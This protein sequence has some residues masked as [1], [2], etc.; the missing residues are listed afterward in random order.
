LLD[1]HRDGA[2][3]HAGALGRP[4][5]EILRRFADRLAAG[6][7]GSRLRGDTLWGALLSHRGEIGSLAHAALGDGARPVRA[8]MFDK[9]PSANWA[10]SWHQDRTIPV[11]ERA[12]A[13]GFGP[14]SRKDGVWHVA[15]PI[16]VL[17]RMVTLRAHL[18]DCDEDNAPLL[19]ALGS[20]RCGKVAATEA[21]AR[22][23]ERPM[24][25]CLAAMGDVW[26][27]RTPILHASERAAR[28]R[29]RRVLQVDF[30]AF[31]LPEPLRWKGLEA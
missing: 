4:T 28:P 20:H 19:I 18:D 9:S 13:P 3:L 24:H 22:A 23:G 17:D 25:T 29:R 12:E 31:D 10:V 1:L 30:A 7:P 21:A 11:A 5:I 26:I 14:W 16:E 15:P 27:Y 2:A 8:V 6:R